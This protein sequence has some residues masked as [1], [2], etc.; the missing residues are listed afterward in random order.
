MAAS[1]S[2]PSAMDE[3]TLRVSSGG[4]LRAYVDRALEV[5]PVRARPAARASLRRVRALSPATPLPDSLA[6]HAP[7]R[8]C[9]TG[10]AVSKAVSVAEI[11]RRRLRGLHQNTQ[12][13]LQ[14]RAEGHRSDPTLA[15]TLSLSPL[16]SALPGYQPPLSEEELRAAWIF[17]ESDA[18]QMDE[19]QAAASVAAP[20][21]QGGPADQSACQSA[22]APLG[23]VRRSRT[24]SRR[25]RRRDSEQCDHERPQQTMQEP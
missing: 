21:P 3:Q 23:A 19:D 13:G 2:A 14:A 6:Q 8:I 11:A 7:L 20:A 24:R 22:D 15:I 1:A 18:V 16:D 10:A 12:I 5:L 9:A 17:E 4:K 25:K